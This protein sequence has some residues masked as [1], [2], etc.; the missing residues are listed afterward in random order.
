MP[1]PNCRLRQP[2]SLE[3]LL[4]YR[5][6]RLYV[7]STSPVT[8]LMEG[9][10]GISRREW[11]LLAV[12]AGV[13]KVSPSALAEQA[14]LDRP[15]TSR[16]ISSLVAKGLAQRSVIADDARRATVSLTASGRQLF[17]EVF[18]QIARMNS[19]LLEAVDDELVQA[20]DRALHVL[21]LRAD[22]IGRSTE[23]QVRANRRAGGSRRVRP[24]ATF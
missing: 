17:E 24:L 8:R 6:F 20:L 9:K 14:H 5:L 13:G 23:P 22:E 3:D 4:N 10:W 2:Q 12:L 1:T 15:R 21:T 7:A 18:P 11:R 19:R 16:A